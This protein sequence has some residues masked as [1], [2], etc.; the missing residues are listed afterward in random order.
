LTTEDDRVFD[1]F[2]GVGST[3]ILPSGIIEGG[4]VLKYSLNMRNAKERLIANSRDNENQTNEQTCYD[5]IEEEI[6]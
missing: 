2:M 5:P 4:S 3:L 1:P 6:V